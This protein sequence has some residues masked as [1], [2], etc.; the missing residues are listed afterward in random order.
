MLPGT[1]EG[2]C[3]A[4]DEMMSTSPAALSAAV[5]ACSVSTTKVL[6]GGFQTMATL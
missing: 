5:I 3:G 4:V 6:S 1:S 2:D